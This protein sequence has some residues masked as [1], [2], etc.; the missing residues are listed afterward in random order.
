MRTSSIA[1]LLLSLHWLSFLPARAE[2]PGIAR[3]YVDDADGRVHIVN[4]AGRDVTIPKEKDQVRCDEP[5]IAE[6][7]RTAGWLVDYENCCTSYPIPLTLVI[8]RDGRIQRR[9]QPGLMIFDWR[10][11]ERGRKIALSQGTVHG[12]TRRSL[13]LY[14]ARTG[15]VLQTW[16]GDFEQ[17]PP[18]W[19][20]G[21]SQ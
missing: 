4:S 21:L 12:M 18:D 10:F 6:D 15:R 8:Y 13:S 7:K 11:V 20:R 9:L 1:V 5:G 19:A 17:T 16:D 14:N 3:V 2:D